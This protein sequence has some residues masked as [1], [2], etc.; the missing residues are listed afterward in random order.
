M[1]STKATPLRLG[2]DPSDIG[3]NDNNQVVQ[4]NQKTDNHN[5]DEV[6]ED[7]PRGDPTSLHPRGGLGM[8]AAEVLVR[9]CHW[10]GSCS[11]LTSVGFLTPAP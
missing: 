3:D 11:S 5:V 8:N 6:G 4:E 10:R 9:F 7:R 1:V 2:L